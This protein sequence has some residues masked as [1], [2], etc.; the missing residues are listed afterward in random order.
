MFEELLRE[1]L[2]DTL[3][4]REE[5]LRLLPLDTLL[6]F[7]ELLRELPLDTLLLREELLR[8]LPPDT[9]LLFEELLLPVR[10]V[11]VVPLLRVDVLTPE[12]LRREEEVLPLRVTVE[13]ERLL[14]PSAR[15]E[16][17]RVGVSEVMTVRRFSSE[18]TFTLRLPSLREGIF[19]YPAL[20][21]RRL[22]S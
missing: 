20:R 14:V 2:L 4:L 15:L 13:V 6:L 5:L 11:P 18:S 16:P 17:V 21:S 7:E 10:V 22:F 12:S 1:L 3:L 19:T 8:R 9:L